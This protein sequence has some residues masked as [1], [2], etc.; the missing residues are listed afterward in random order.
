MIVA[1][2]VLDKTFKGMGQR[3]EARRLA[4]PNIGDCSRLASMRDLTP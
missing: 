3:H 2:A 1:L 4:L